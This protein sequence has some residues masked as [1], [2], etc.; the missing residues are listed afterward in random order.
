MSHLQQFPHHRPRRLRKDDFTRR[1]VREHALTSND[2]IYPVFVL[3]QD[4]G[5]Q[6]IASMPGVSNAWVA[7]PC[8]PPPSNA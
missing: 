3:D 4:E 8:M 7:A 2:L 5:T 6:A 1:L